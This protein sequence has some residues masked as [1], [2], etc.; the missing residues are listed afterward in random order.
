[1]SRLILL[2]TCLLLRVSGYTPLHTVVAS[3]RR[4][5]HRAAILGMSENDVKVTIK[6]PTSSSSSGVVEPTVETKVTVRVRKPS[7]ESDA[8][9]ADVAPATEDTGYTTS[10]KVKKPEPKV[11][12]PKPQRPYE[13]ELL[14]NATQS[15]N[16]TLLLEALQ[17][18]VNPNIRDPKGRT[19]LHFMAGVGLAPACVLLIH[20]GAQLDVQDE[21]G[22]TPLHMAAGYANARS[23]RVLVAAG[24]DLELAGEG[25][26]KAVDVVK[27][28][29]EYQYEQFFEGKTKKDVFKKKDEKLEKLK[30]CLDVL[31]NPEEVRAEKSWDEIVEETMRVLAI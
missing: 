30:G 7:E 9:S 19:P 12:A 21:G 28:L 26:D 8:P 13:E 29:G 5:L 31:L 22:L 2:T 4:T 6:K 23:L 1:M 14:L 11:A 10:I 27:K 3:T 20:F 25:Q 18:G 16:C 24:A 15:A 17:L